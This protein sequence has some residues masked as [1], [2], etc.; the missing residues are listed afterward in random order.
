VVKG[1]LDKTPEIWEEYR[2]IVKKHFNAFTDFEYIDR[3]QFYERAR[4][5]YSIIATSEKA[6]YGVIILKKGVL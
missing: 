3:F 2:N 5:A 4:N 1:T 6:L